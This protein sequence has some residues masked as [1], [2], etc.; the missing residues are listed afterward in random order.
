MS[1]E[2]IFKEFV[3]KGEKISKWVTKTGET[4]YDSNGNEIH[5][6]NSDG[7]EEWCEYDSNGNLIH[8]KNSKGEEWWY[9]YDSNGNE[10]H[11]KNSYGEEWCENEYNSEG[12]L[13]RRTEYEL[14]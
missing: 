1:E 11:K 14:I 10:I 5:R 3:V 2:K 4:Q 6:K 8:Y 13:I 9:E 12:K 7:Y